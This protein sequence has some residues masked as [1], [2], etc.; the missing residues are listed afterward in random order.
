M[1]DSTFPTIL[2]HLFQLLEA[3]RGIFRQERTYLRA[4]GLLIGELFVFARHTV[5]QELLALGLSEG[6]WS[7]WYR[8]FSRKRFDLEQASGHVFTQTLAHVAVEQPYGIGVDGVQV[9]RSS[10]KMAGTSWLKAPWTPKFKAG[11]HRAQRFLNLSWLTP[12]EEGFS[13]AIPLRWLPA[14][15]E[16]AVLPA[17]LS[18]CKEWEAGLEAIR[19]VRSQ[20]DAA[21]RQGQWLLALA[22]GNF[23]KVVDFW[24][25]LPERTVVLGRSARNRVLD[26][27]PESC[28]VGRPPDFG[29]RARKPAEWL[30]ERRG[31]TTL[32]VPVRGHGREMRSRVEG[33]FLRDG[34]PDRPL[35]L[36]V[37]R[38]S[39]R[40]L[41]GGRVR[42]DPSFYLVSAVQQEGNW[43]LPLP[44]EI[45]LTWAWQRWK[46]EVEHRELKSGFGLGEKQ[47]W[48]P[49]AAVIP[50][51]WTTWVSAVLLLAGSRTWGLLGGPPG[52]GR[53][54]HGSRRWSF[55]TLWR[56]YRAAFWKNADFRAVWTAT[57]ENWLRKGDWMAGLWN[58]VAG[59]A[60]V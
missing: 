43:L 28:G 32:R 3:Q 25:G 9:P 24:K 1:K 58:S 51:Q 13:R 26:H 23:E 44:V 16:K 20:L 38:G 10:Q 60:R 35:F 11:I 18:P 22:D 19:W 15:P 5:T 56:A 6:D 46:L 37:V 8:L 48:N 39:D 53:W 57:G 29:K 59:A 50:V 31:W 12:L 21:G 40:Q 36:I 17:G 7:P 55:N 52:P 47:C 45:L 27:L 4:L 41:K 42:R 54:W 34:L 2:Q 33:P 30:K 14:F 49:H